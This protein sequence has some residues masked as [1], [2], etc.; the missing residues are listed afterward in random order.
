M[1]GQLPTEDT[2][3][4]G[5]FGHVFNF[6][7]TNKGQFTNLFQYTFIAV[8]LVIIVLKCMNYFTPE[9]DET[10]GTL[11]ITLD[12]VFSLVWIILGIWFINKII[13]YIPT[14]S[15]MPY[16]IFNETNFVIPLLLILFTMNTKLGTK[17]NILIDRYVDVYNGNV[18]LK[19]ND[20]NV[21]TTQPIANNQRA[22]NAPQGR[23][24]VYGVPSNSNINLNQPHRHPGAES[25]GR[26][27]HQLHRDT[28]QSQ[29]QQHNFN[30]DFA[31]PQINALLQQENTKLAESFSNPEPMA[32]NEACGGSFGSIF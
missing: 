15:K 19:N 20:P 17:L 6:D 3:K 5:F 23:D 25:E 9:V 2:K 27:T 10:K 16:P 4:L 12:I 18:N 14:F 30:N 26:H 11:E 29:A 1:E 32:A 28:V 8:P 13:R 24:A 7:D 22:P 31:G 21:K